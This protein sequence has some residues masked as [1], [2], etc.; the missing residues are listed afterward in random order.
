MLLRSFVPAMVT[1]VG[2]EEEATEPSKES[3]NQDSVRSRVMMVFRHGVESEPFDTPWQQAC[4]KGVF[5]QGQVWTILTLLSDEPAKP[6]RIP[7]FEGIPMYCGPWD[8]TA[9]RPSRGQV[10]I[11]IECL[12]A[13]DLQL[14]AERV[15]RLLVSA[16]RKLMEAGWNR[17]PGT[18]IY[19]SALAMRELPRGLADV[20]VVRPEDLKDSDR[21]IARQLVVWAETPPEGRPR[22]AGLPVAIGPSRFWWAPWMVDPRI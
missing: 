7:A 12:V 8:G 11:A 18:L 19:G 1:R 5:S 21:D 13:K 9:A 4:S 3:G 6:Y 16:P 14:E 22:W 20:A 10:G 15:R 17:S 2:D